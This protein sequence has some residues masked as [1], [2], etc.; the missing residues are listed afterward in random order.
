[1]VEARAQLGYAE[2][3][4]QCGRYA[5]AI[6]LAQTAATTFSE[7]SAAA[8]ASSRS[9]L[10]AVMAWYNLGNAAREAKQLDLAESALQQAV[11]RGRANLK[12]NPT[13]PNTRFT[14]AAALVEQGRLRQVQAERREEARAS[15]DEAVAMLETLAG[16]FPT[17]ASFA[18][19]LTDALTARGELCA[20]TGQWPAAMADARRAIEIAERLDRQSSGAAGYQG[21]TRL[22]LRAGWPSR[23]EA[24]ARGTGTGCTQQGPTANR[25]GTGRQPR[26]PALDRK[27]GRS[28]ITAAANR[29]VSQ[30]G[31]AD[32]RSASPGRALRSGVIRTRYC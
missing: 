15:F 17:T 3:L 4:Q 6:P 25:E 28:R 22:R 11:E 8:G 27:S 26:Q 1:M 19:R 10:I 16:Q 20:G 23:T 24:G 32:C 21:A 14:L 12:L 9:R 13:E 18:R 29:Q 5:E 2:V 7:S 30:M 31:R